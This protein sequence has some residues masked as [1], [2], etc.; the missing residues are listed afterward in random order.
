MICGLDSFWFI[1]LYHHVLLSTNLGLHQNFVEL[2]FRVLQQW[3][4]GNLSTNLGLH[5]SFVELSIRVLQQWINGNWILQIIQ[6]RHWFRNMYG[7]ET[8]FT[9]SC[10]I[11]L[12]YHVLVAGA[13]VSQ[14]AS[15]VLLS[16]CHDPNPFSNQLL[17]HCH[18]HEC[19]FTFRMGWVNGCLWT[20]Y[21]R[22]SEWTSSF[23]MIPWQSFLSYS[24]DLDSVSFCLKYVLNPDSQNSPSFLGRDMFLDRTN[25]WFQKVECFKTFL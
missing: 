17:F 1:L 14:H 9:F 5:Q 6:L 2:R 4:N 25:F 15:V 18:G 8:G 12:L 13:V 7:V 11:R 24:D 23:C 20:V 3:I 22:Y 21:E 16:G 10:A 19:R